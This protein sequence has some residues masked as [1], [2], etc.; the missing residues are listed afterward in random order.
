MAGGG[1]AEQVKVILIG[2][3]EYFARA[4]GTNAGF[5]TALFRDALNR[6]LDPGGEAFFTSQ[7]THG[8]PSSNV[9]SQVASSLEA[10]QVVTD[11]FYQRF[12]H[13]SADR[14]GRGFF[15]NALLHGL[16]DEEVISSLTGSDEYLRSL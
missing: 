7:L 9:A 5:L 3:A 12:L 6:P 16:R 13:R 15:A 10:A 1:T 4:G 2:S 8:V 11:G 14:D